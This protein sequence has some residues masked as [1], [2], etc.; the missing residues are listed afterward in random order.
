M[1]T[2]IQIGCGARLRVPQ[3]RLDVPSRNPCLR[4]CRDRPTHYL[5]VQ[6]GKTVAVKQ[7][8]SI[9]KTGWPTGDQPVVGRLLVVEGRKQKGY[10]AVALLFAG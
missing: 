2:S 6:F 10:P 9:G 4:L 1:S 7:Q 8:R 3:M 5:E